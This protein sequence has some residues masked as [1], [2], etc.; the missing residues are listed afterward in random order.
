MENIFIEGIQ[1]SGKTTIMKSLCDKLDGY[2]LYWE[3]D[4]SPVE[5]AWCS[6]MTREEYQQALA[7]FPDL[8]S[9]IKAYTLKEETHVIIAY[10]RILAD[11]RE[12]YQHME[13]YELY[14]GRRTFKGFKDIILNRL[15]K[16]DGTGNLFEGSFFQNMIEELLLFYCKPE[17]EILDF[18]RELFTVVNQKKFRLIYLYSENIESN[19]LKIKGERSDENGVEM[20]F[21]LM[22]NYLNDSPYGREHAFLDVTDM[23]SHFE[24]RSK[25]EMRIIKEILGEYAMV[26]PAKAYDIEE[27]VKWLMECET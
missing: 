7:M 23:A 6:Y 2:Q 15:G 1:G 11:R 17:E 14:N 13:R 21:P 4:I 12:F 5:L 27:V 24:R 10:T 3:G 26:L 22:M 9:E 19:I 18:Y 20:W 16:F 25:L 8:A